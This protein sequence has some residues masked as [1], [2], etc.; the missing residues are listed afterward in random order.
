MGILSLDLLIKISCKNRSQLQSI[1][2]KSIA[3]IPARGGSK[4]IPRKNIKDFLGKP[5]IAYSIEAALKSGLFDEV[6]VSTD[7][8][9]IA[10]IAKQ[11][12]ASVPFFRSK[13]TSDDYA[14]LV[15]VIEEIILRYEQQGVYFD[16]ICC[17]LPTAPF[18]TS[19]RLIEGFNLLEENKYDSITPVI[20]YSYPI[21]RALQIDEN[22]RLSMIYPENMC[23]RSQDLVPV[24]HDS[25]QFYWGRIESFMNER[26][27]FMKN[28]GAII[29]SENEG[30]DI[31]TMEDWQLAE[32]K[33]ELLRYSK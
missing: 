9:E 12:E 25:G 6:M 18:I 30:Q 7:S 2:S 17:I 4:R 29:I 27:F 1:M 20:Q 19:L 23:K 15:D 31:D 10:N 14:T 24:Y 33:Y 22:N 11:Y 28:G 32:M 26:T 8:E 3:I 21:Q 13:K 5:I 16:T